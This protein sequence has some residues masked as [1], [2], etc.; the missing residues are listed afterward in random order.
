MIYFISSRVVR[1]ILTD[2][3]QKEKCL[4]AVRHLCD[5]AREAAH[6]LLAS[7]ETLRSL[8]TVDALGELDKRLLVRLYNRFS[9]AF[10]IAE[11]IDT[12]AILTVHGRAI[13]HRRFGGRN[14]LVLPCQFFQRTFS[15]SHVLI[16]EDE[17]DIQFY[18]VIGNYYASVRHGGGYM[19]RVTPAPGG[20]ANT[21]KV[22]ARYRQGGAHFSLCI[23]DSD[24]KMPGSKLGDTAKKVKLHGKT[25]L[26]DYLIIDVR[27]SENI[28][29]IDFF[30]ECDFDARHR[31]L[32][33]RFVKNSYLNCDSW[34]YVDVKCGTSLRKVLKAGH[35]HIQ[36][37]TKSNYNGTVLDDDGCR[38]CI[39]VGCSKGHEGNACAFYITPPM[40]DQTLV[41]FINYASRVQPIE[42]KRHISAPVADHWHGIGERLASWF[43]APPEP[44]AV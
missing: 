31:E 27:D 38:G 7:P 39:E 15:Q 42:M 36:Y 17:T 23:I 40:G 13:R 20:G 8:S 44:V 3:P 2:G 10:S 43:C 30:F 6:F 11:K 5:G 1:E 9:T 35:D 21:H 37:W 26:S 4:I 22:Y 14:V 41:K 34:K 29:P 19:I 24:I 32:Y 18:Q 16:G 25:T 28:L 33:V 12:V